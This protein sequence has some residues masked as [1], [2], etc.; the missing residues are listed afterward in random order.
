MKRSASNSLQLRK[1]TLDDAKGIHELIRLFANR[2]KDFL[3]P[4]SLTDIYDNIRDYYI[5]VTPRKGVNKRDLNLDRKIDP[6]TQKIAYYNANVMPPPNSYGVS[7]YPNR[8]AAI[9]AAAILET[10][11]EARQRIASG[12]PTPAH[13]VPTPP[14]AESDISQ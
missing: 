8:K 1:A 5:C 9:A 3:L 2:K 7:I 11:D 13:Y 14:I 10:P 4:R 6:A 12:G